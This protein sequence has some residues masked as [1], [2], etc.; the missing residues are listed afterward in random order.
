VTAL[1]QQAT[2]LAAIRTFVT[3]V[4]RTEQITRNV[5]RSRSVVATS[6]RSRPPPPTSS[7]TCSPRLPVA[8]S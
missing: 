4:V 6:R 8:T 3:N 2:E 7:S 5:R 1:E